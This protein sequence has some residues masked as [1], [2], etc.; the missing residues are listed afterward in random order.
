[1]RARLS[2]KIEKVIGWYYAN[3][4]G[5]TLHLTTV[6]KTLRLGW[7]QWLEKGSQ[8]L[9]TNYNI[10]ACQIGITRQEAQSPTKLLWFWSNPHRS[11]SLMSGLKD[12]IVGW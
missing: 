8:N 12:G 4:K 7:E 1:M 6:L 2:P 5:L 10:A 3:P 11:V 9:H